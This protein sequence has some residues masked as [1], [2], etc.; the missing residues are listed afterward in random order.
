[1]YK[2]IIF[3]TGAAAT[4]VLNILRKD[5]CEIV[6]FLDNNSRRWGKYNNIDVKD[7]NEIRN[8]KYD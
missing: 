4:E 8:I 1:M 3:G 7:P 5:A 6:C 2:V